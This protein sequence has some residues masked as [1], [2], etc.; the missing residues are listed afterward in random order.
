[1]S[2][3]S[4]GWVSA[5]GQAFSSYGGGKAVG[6][7]VSAGTTYLVGERGPELFTPNSGGTITPNN[8]M[9]GAGGG[10]TV[11][12]YVTVNSGDSGEQDKA[13]QARAGKQLAG[14]IEAK[15][16]EVVLRA[17]QPGGILWKQQH[18]VT[19]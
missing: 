16:K 12:S 11:N 13:D 14:L 15:S 1:M 9:H 4:V 18:G 6:G 8:Q 5:L 3:S 2:G 17:M 19:A 10:I 7:P